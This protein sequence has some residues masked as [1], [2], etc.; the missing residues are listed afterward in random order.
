MV[1]LSA[2]LTI[3]LCCGFALAAEFNL[4]SYQPKT[5]GVTDDTPALQRCFADVAKA[6]GGVV[7]IPAGDYYV[8]GEASI[9]LSSRTTVFAHG[10][11]FHLPE[12]LGDKARIVLFS[13]T[14][15]SD[16]TWQGGHFAGHCFDHRRPPNTWEPN[17]NTRIIVISTSEGG[18]TDQLTFR[19]ITSERV[20]G[21][22]INVEGCGKPGSESEVSTFAT[23]VTVEN[24]TLV[25]SGKFMWDYGLL[26][27]IVVWPEDY[28]ADDLAMAKRYFRNDLIREGVR[29]AD[30]D[31]RVLFDNASRTV[32]VSATEGP[33]DVVCFYGDA[34]PKNV[35]RGKRYFVVASTKEYI[36]V[37]ERF[38]G[39]PMKF[40][41]TS[42][43]QAKLIHN[44]QG[45]FYELYAPTGAGPGKGS[46]DLVCCRNVR[47]TGCKLSALGDTM[48]IQR[49][50]NVIFTN[51]HITG[52]RMG[53]FFL[54]EY[55]KNSNVTGNLI[56]GT[57]GSR[58]M[59]IEKSNEDVTIIGNTFRNGG[60]GSWINQPKNLVMQGNIFI[61]NTTKCEADPWRGR[62]TFVTG[63]WERYPEMYFTLH[64]KD[65]QYGPV[66]LRDNIFETGPEAKAAIHFERN[67]HDVLVEGNLFRGAQR[68][69]TVEAGTEVIFGANPGA[70]LPTEQNKEQRK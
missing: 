60:R 54:A 67:G 9:P 28:T 27:Q 64:Q 58:V 1:F 63:D 30:G 20:A 56:D 45:A 52:S 3:A 6:G 38:Q 39:P 5:D 24:C 33:R 23:N 18:K 34:L 70:Q 43:P 31:N 50:H 37:S 10:A 66:I 57:N 61:N 29:M 26:W 21:A 15:V 48:H 14:D 41:G 32:L 4:S 40:D 8:K 13:G 68:A 62:R 2:F 11:R 42:G 44:L 19:D 17:A 22:V 65:G 16:F 35:V 46:V 51:N 12:K 36:Q 53:A 47:V 55:C 7:T 49:C 25:D 69:V 59:S